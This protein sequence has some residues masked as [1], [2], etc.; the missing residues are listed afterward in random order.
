MSLLLA[1]A[2]AAA[3]QAWTPGPADAMSTSR[4]DEG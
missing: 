4:V 1:V 2:V 3:L